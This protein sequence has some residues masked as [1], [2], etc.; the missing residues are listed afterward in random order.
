MG[1]VKQKVLP[2]PSLANSPESTAMCLDDRAVD[3]QTHADAL[4]LCR[5]LFV[6]S[7]ELGS[8]LLKLSHPVRRARAGVILAP[9]PGRQSANR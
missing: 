6:G 8:S 4:R 9:A 2:G 1:S 5:V 3:F 7:F